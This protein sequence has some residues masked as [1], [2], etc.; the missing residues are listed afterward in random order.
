MLAVVHVLGSML[1]LFSVTYV[2]PIVTSAIY[3]DGLLADFVVAA[4]I[5]WSLPETL[6]SS[7][8]YR[9]F[10]AEAAVTGAQR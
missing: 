6:Q 9:G 4:L 10:R 3:A 7:R 2:L 1:M 5:W 8:L